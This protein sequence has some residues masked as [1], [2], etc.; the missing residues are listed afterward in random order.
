MYGDTKQSEADGDGGRRQRTES[1]RAA[2]VPAGAAGGRQTVEAQRKAVARL[3][4]AQT[5]LPHVQ[6]ALIQLH[7]DRLKA[8][9]ADKA[10]WR[11]LG[12]E[13]EARCVGP[14]RT[15]SSWR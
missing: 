2:R 13:L 7:M 1:G 3:E 8:L 9:E 12:K 11:K 15:R 10:S 5:S 4:A 6:T 14:S